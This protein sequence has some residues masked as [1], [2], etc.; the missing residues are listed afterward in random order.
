MITMARY[1]PT[2]YRPKQLANLDP[3][4]I[5]HKRHVEKK[6]LDE[7]AKEVGCSVMTMS[8]FCHAHKIARPKLDKKLTLD[9]TGRQFGKLIVLRP[10]DKRSHCKCI[11]WECRCTMEGCGAIIERASNDLMHGKKTNQ[12]CGCYSAVHNYRGVGDLSGSYYNAIRRGAA[13]RALEFALTKEE[14]WELFLQQG[15][16]CAL[17]GVELRLFRSLRRGDRSIQ[18]ASVDRIDSSRGYTSNNVQWIHKDLQFMKSN[19]TDSQFIE[20][21]RRVTERHLE[22]PRR[23]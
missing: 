20:W 5:Y 18:T 12:S 14:L 4:V 15:R 21:C 9:L 2:D 17:S 13:S 6:T 23:T 19:L 8:R 10:L 1:H 16:K 22:L 7:I 3:Q 11:I